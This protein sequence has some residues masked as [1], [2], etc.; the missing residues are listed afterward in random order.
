MAFKNLKQ[1]SKVITVCRHLNFY[2][3]IALI[4]STINKSLTYGLA[5]I[6]KII[7]KSCQLLTFCWWELRLW[8]KMEDSNSIYIQMMNTCSIISVKLFYCYRGRE[9]SNVFHLKNNHHW[10]LIMKV[11]ILSFTTGWYNKNV[12]RSHI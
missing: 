4:S 12:N 8:I 3:L 2:K 11:K 7:R 1:M 10:I 9:N 6:R 5:Y